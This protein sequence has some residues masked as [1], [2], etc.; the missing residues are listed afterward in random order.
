MMDKPKAVRV[1]S[2]IIASNAA[3]PRTKKERIKIRSMLMAGIPY[4]KIMKEYNIA[5]STLSY[6]KNNKDKANATC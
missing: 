3:N 6:M 5:K 2:A 1:R 4:S